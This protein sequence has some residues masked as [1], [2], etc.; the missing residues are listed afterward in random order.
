MD[1]GFKIMDY[2]FKIQDFPKML[3]KANLQKLLT[4]ELS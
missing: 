2:G 4:N 3:D 1:Y